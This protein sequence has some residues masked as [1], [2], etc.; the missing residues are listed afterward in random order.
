M[1]SF[2]KFMLVVM[3]LLGVFLIWLFRRDADGVPILSYHQI[4]DIDKNSLTLTPEEF[5]AQMKYLADNGY[6]F[7]FPD[8][9]LD[10]WENQIPLPK[11][12]VVVTFSG[13]RL[14]IYKTALPILQKYN[15]KAT[16]FVIT[17][18]LN[19]YPTYITWEQ[20]RELQSGGV[21]DIESNTLNHENLAELLSTQD[22]RNQLINS[23]QAVEWYIKKP[24]N[25]ISFPGGMYTREVEQLTRDVG[26]RAAF[27][28]DYGL[29]HKGH[30]VLP[31][32][33]IFGNNSH[34]FLRFKIRLLCAPIIAPLN[35]LKNSMIYDG[36][37][38]LAQYIWIP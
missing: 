2:L 5:E 7:M 31:T 11:K 18:F 30:Y 37:G 27:A 25:Y 28:I 19:L 22:V 17:D 38:A 34:T 4:N 15:A 20:A 26:Y 33:P 12:P 14:D 13:G 3:V 10:A 16:L 9:V 6:T 8:E 24:A 21:F 23:K 32:I 35:R 36:N 1:K 29:A